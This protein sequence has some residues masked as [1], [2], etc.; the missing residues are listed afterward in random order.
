MIIPIRPPSD[1]T[2]QNQCGESG[3][4]P[5]VEWVMIELNGE[6]LKPSLEDDKTKHDTTTDDDNRR[7]LE[8]GSVKFDSSVS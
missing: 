5:V 1:T 3:S 8:L 6:L 2:Q 7:H 4:I